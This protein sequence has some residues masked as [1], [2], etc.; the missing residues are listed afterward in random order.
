MCVQNN[1]I[2]LTYNKLSLV[3]YIMGIFVIYT[4]IKIRVF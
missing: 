2:M 4:F 3:I 1:Y